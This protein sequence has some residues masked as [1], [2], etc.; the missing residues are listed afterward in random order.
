MTILRQ[1]MIHDMQI[2]N[3][4]P[5]TQAS[6]LQQVSQFAKYFNKSPAAL[7][8]EEIRTYQIYLTADR[9]LSP[10]SIHIAICTSFPL[11]AFPEKGVGL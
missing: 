10:S 5:H 8:P 3:P 11:Q 2:R 7:G 1:R 4:S 6:Y 9:K